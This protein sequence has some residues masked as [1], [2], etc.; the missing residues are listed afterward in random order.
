MGIVVPAEGMG[1][2]TFRS[3]LKER[4]PFPVKKIPI[5]TFLGCPH[6]EGGT[7]KGG[8]FYCNNASFA[9]LGEARSLGVREQVRLGIERARQRG[10]RGKFILYFQTY[11][12]TFAP[13]EVLEEQ[14]GVAYEFRDDVVGL[15]VST[16]PDCLEGDVLTLLSRYA[17][18][19][20]LWLEI[21]LQTANDQTLRLINRGHDFATFRG[22]VERA[23][24]FEGILTCAHVILGLPG[25]TREDMLN[26]IEWV[27]R[28]KLDGIKIHHL[29]VVKGTVFEEWYRQGRVRVMDWQEYLDLLLY[30][31]PRL[32]PRIVVHRLVSD[33]PPSL[34]VAPHW[35]ISKA[36]F[37]SRLYRHLN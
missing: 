22:A 13:V 31:L 10:F 20:M 27:N 11:T 28:L 35:D 29:Q 24:R 3:Y 19:F 23:R 32:D 12:N 15:S 30:L 26:T 21:G 36:E 25:E 1:I 33:C 8:C 2:R 6:R 16:R 34:L 9:S 17:K 37:L 5:H 7:G 18:D 14:F 4:F